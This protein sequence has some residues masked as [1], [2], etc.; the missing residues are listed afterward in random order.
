MATSPQQGGVTGTGAA[1]HTG[2]RHDCPTCTF[3]EELPEGSPE[4]RTRIRHG[5]CRRYAP[6]PA[7][8]GQAAYALWA[9]VHSGDWCGEY[10]QADD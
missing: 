6:R 2:R 4:A 1:P 8:G 3:F 7:F 5:W 9:N 10:V